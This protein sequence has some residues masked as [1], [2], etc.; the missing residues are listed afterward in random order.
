MATEVVLGRDIT[1]PEGV[2]PSDVSDGFHTFREVYRFRLAYNALLF[3]EWARAGVNQVHK[4][5][6]HHDGE[7]CFGGAYFVVVAVLPAGQITNHYKLEHWDLFKIPEFDTARVPY[8]GHTPQDTLSRMV[9]FIRGSQ[10][11]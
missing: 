2:R 1:L 9:D 3:N 4:S 10:R 7:L 5:K 6:R 11:P 8:D